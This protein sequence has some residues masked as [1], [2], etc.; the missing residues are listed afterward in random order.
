MECQPGLWSWKYEHGEFEVNFVE[1][2]TF[3]CK[4]YPDHSHWYNKGEGKVFVDWGQ[5]GKYDMQLS[6]STEMKGSYSGYPDE[7]RTAKFIRAHTD[8]EKADFASS[9]CGGHHHDH[10]HGADCGHHH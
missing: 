7:W 2:G 5:F 9:S 1:G 3:V 8:A 6:S 10:A 4:S